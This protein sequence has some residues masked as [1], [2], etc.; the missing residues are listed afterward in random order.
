LFERA[1]ARAWGAEYGSVF[2]GFGPDF[3]VCDDRKY[4]CVQAETLACAALLGA[5][6]GNAVHR[7]WYDRL[8]AYCW[9]NWVDHLHGAW[10]RSLSRTNVNTTDEKSPARKGR[11]PHDGRVLRHRRGTE[12]HLA[13]R[14]L[15]P[16]ATCP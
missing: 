6:T 8:W 7:D 1:L 9:Q 12:A 15:M 16:V 2:Y 14:P 13:S 3:A 4:H 5:R 10:F 11:P